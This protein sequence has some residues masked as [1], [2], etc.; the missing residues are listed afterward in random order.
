LSIASH[1]LRTP[2]HA[3]VINL[4]HV[5]TTS[6]PASPSVDETRSRIERA[7]R[8]TDRLARIIDSLYDVS[9]VSAGQLHIQRELLDLTELCHDVAARFADQAAVSGGRIDVRA[10]SPA[11]GS[12]DRMRIEQVLTN[13]V[14][15]A[16]KYGA[17]QPVLLSVEP[18]PDSVRLR[19]QDHGI[20]IPEED[21][22]RVFERYQRSSSARHFGG[23]GLG[24]FIARQIVEAHGG[25]ISLHS[26]RGEGTVFSVELPRAAHDALD[27]G[28]ERMVASRMMS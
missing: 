19:V 10:S 24:L 23:L 17:G 20:G 1:E 27:A 26:R 5:R 4:S 9:R 16:L 14:S 25:T 12:W 13:L 28:A 11:L 21:Q 22:S 6:A 18:G 2:L 15:N 3:L 7:V 8:Q